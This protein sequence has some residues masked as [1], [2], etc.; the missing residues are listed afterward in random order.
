MYKN[1][2]S[3]TVGILHMSH[4]SR[5]EKLRCINAMTHDTAIRNILQTYSTIRMN[6]TYRVQEASLRQKKKETKEGRGEGR[7]EERRGK[8]YSC[9][10]LFTKSSKP[11]ITNLC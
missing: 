11:V 4:S 8:E 10:I 2:Y 1:V 6:L 9:V 3:Q 7:R 5:M